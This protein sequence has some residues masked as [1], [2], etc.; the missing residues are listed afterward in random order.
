MSGRIGKS[1]EIYVQISGD[2]PKRARVGGCQARC[3]RARRARR[4]HRSGVR[5]VRRPAASR[6][7]VRVVALVGSHWADRNCRRLAVV[8]TD[9]HDPRRGG[10]GVHRILPR[11]PTSASTGVTEPSQTVHA[12]S[13]AAPRPRAPRSCRCRAC[14]GPLGLAL[15]S[16]HP[17]PLARDN[18]RPAHRV[19]TRSHAA[20]PKPIALI[21]RPMR[22]RH[23]RV[24]ATAA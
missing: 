14:R 20:S 18:W 1:P 19:P 2:S 3:A 23:G 9:A 6:P 22:Q 13:D 10:S 12:P 15:R 21:A 16:S 17:D 7:K 11:A 8:R 4:E 5:R 24:A